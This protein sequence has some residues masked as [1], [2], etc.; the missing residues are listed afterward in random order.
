MKFQIEILDDELSVEIDA[1][2]KLQWQEIGKGF[3]LNIDWVTYFDMQLTGM[4]V[5]FTLR[6]EG[7]L[8]G[9]CSFVIANHIHHS[10]VLLASQDSIYILPIYR[11]NGT[12]IE[13]ID[14]IEKNLEDEGVDH[15]VM[16]VKPDKD[17]SAHLIK[18]GYWAEETAYLK[19]LGG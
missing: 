17:Y 10:G 12:F 7:K 15:I 5:I 4:L 1:L 2:L 11:R 13:F 16:S 8:I 6:K 18:H 14:F 9:Y 19:I 3:D